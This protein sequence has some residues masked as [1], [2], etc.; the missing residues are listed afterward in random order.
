M[1]KIKKTY[2]NIC[3]SKEATF[4]VHSSYK[5]GYII[6]LLESLWAES[7]NISKAIPILRLDF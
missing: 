7:R 6:D 4:D 3:H 5:V 2:D 1:H